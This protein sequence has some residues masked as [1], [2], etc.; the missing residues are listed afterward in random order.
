VHHY[1]VLLDFS[2]GD[3]NFGTETTVTFACR[4]PGTGTFI[5]FGG[6]SVDVVQLNGEVLSTRFEGGRMQLDALAAQNSLTVKGT[7]LYS[8]VGAGISWFRDP[9]DGRTYLHSQF[10]EHSTYLG[11]ACF[12]QPDLKA[13]FGFTVKTP[14][15]LKSSMARA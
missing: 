1:D 13:T 12:D 15:R 2:M 5:E 11:Y 3:E 14:A 7:G 4:T 9:V 6:P 10:A 8:H